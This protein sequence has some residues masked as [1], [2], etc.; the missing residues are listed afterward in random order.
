MLL[1][2]RKV[3]TRGKAKTPPHR[4]GQA[5]A[6]TKA[7]SYSPGTPTVGDKPDHG[8]DLCGDSVWPGGDCQVDE[9]SK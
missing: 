7:P 2:R 6:P 9:V 8:D 5:A 1:S 3:A 4:A